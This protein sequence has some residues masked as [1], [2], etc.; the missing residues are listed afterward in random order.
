[1]TCV[2]VCF[3]TADSEKIHVLIHVIILVLSLV[4]NIAKK[5]VLTASSLLLILI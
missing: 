2:I 5:C 1:M 4:L 3:T